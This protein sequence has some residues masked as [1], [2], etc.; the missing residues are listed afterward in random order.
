MKHHSRWRVHG[1]TDDP[2][3]GRDERF[4]AKWVPEPMTSCYLWM[5]AAGNGYGT[6]WTGERF[7]GAHVYA[8]ERKYGP[9]HPGKVLDHVVCDT[10]YCV[11]PDHVRPRTDRQ[12]ILRGAGPSALNSRKVRCSRGHLL[13]GENLYVVPVTGYRQCR[14]CKQA[15]KAAFDQ[16]ERERRA[17]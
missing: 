8:Y 13:S 17:V 4:D 2:R 7:I 5:G 12:N 3:P 6:F 1:S 9:V 16:R 11:N 14:T 10:S 15:S